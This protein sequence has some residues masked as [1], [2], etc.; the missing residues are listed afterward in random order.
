MIIWVFNG[1][2]AGVIRMDVL[3][4]TE[5]EICNDYNYIVE[6][7]LYDH[8]E[9]LGIHMD[10]CIYIVAPSEKDYKEIWV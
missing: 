10:D 6:D 2:T 4:K 3:P 9:E 8:E 1:Q 5:E 7:W